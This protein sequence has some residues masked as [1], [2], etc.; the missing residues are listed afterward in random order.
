[1]GTLPVRIPATEPLVFVLPRPPLDPEAGPGPAPPDPGF[2]P[3]TLAPQ[4]LM[5]GAMLALPPLPPPSE[6]RPLASFRCAPLARFLFLIT[7][8]LS[9]SGRTTPC[10]LRN[11]PHA[12]HKGWPSG[13]RRQRGVLVVWQLEQTVGGSAVAIELAEGRS[14]RL[15]PEPDEGPGPGPETER[16]GAPLDMGPIGLPLDASLSAA[17][18]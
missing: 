3:G 16:T 17:A 9:D 7:S 15:T 6:P 2:P 13:S 14:F 1:M 4:L 11:R 10:N 5:A 8:V 18:F 12:L